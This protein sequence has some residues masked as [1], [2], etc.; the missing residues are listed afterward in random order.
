[1][2]PARVVATTF[3]RKA[4]Q[5]IRTRVTRELERL[6]L[7]PATSVYSASLGLGDTLSDDEVRVH[8][9]RAMSRLPAARFG[10]LHSFAMGIVRAHAMELGLGPGFELATELDSRALAE[11][12]IARAL[13]SRL[14]Q[15]E[16]VVR[17][18]AEA[19]GGVERLVAELRN[20]LVQLEEDGRSARDLAMPGGDVD[21]IERLVAALVEHAQSLTGAPKFD[22]AARDL[23]RAWQGGDEAAV[24]SATVA[25]CAIPALG[26]KSPEVEAFA[27]FRKALVGTTNE[28]KGRRLVRIY[29]MRHQFFEHARV[30]RDLLA[31]AEVD[32]ERESR[33]RAAIGFGEILRAARELLRD[34]PDVAADVGASI[35]A[36]LVDEFQDTSR[37]QRD[38]L[39]LLWAKNEVR[40]AG[41]VPS[42][43]SVRHRGLLVVGDR[44][45]SIYGFRGADVGV[46]A[47]LAVGL[48]GEPARQALGIAPGVTWEPREPLADFCALRYNR[49]SVAEVL[50]FVNAFSARRFCPADPPPALYEI[51]YVPSTEDLLVPPERAKHEAV[52][53]PP[54]ARTT[55]LRVKASGPTSTRMEEALVIAKRISTL[56]DSGAFR[57]KESEPPKPIAYRDLAVLASTNG[58]LDALAFALAQSNIPYV[59]AG[60]GF[61]RTREVRDLAAMLAWIVEPSDGQAALEVLRGPWAGLHDETLLALVRLSGGLMGVDDWL[62]L[63][64]PTPDASEDYRMLASIGALVTELARCA[65]RLGPGAVL[66]EVV[67]AVSFE[68]VL[69]ALPR[70]AQR[71]ANVRK[72]LIL[73][74]M[75]T[76][77][78]EFLAWLSEA[79]ERELGESEAATFSRDDDA[80]RLLTIHASKG[81]DFPVVFIPEIGTTRSR[82]DKGAVRVRTGTGDEPNVLSVRAAD[83]HGLVLE[84]PSFAEAHASAKRRD[85]AERQR[86]A[87]VAVTR[88]ADALYLVGGRAQE[89]VDVGASTLAV[90]EGLADPRASRDACFAIEEVDV[91]CS[92]TQRVE[93][94]EVKGTDVVGASPPP[95]VSRSRAWRSLP[96]APTALADFRSCPRRFELLHVVGLPERPRSRGVTAPSDRPVEVPGVALDAR[97][98]GT[99]AHAVLERVSLAAFGAQNAQEYVRE[100]ILAEGVIDGHPHYASVVA[101]VVPFLRGTFASAAAAAGASWRREV[102]FVL[103]IDAADGRSVVLRGT[104][105]LVVVWPDGSVDVVDYKSA[106]SG[107]SSAHAFQLDTYGLAARSLFP[108]AKRLRVGLLFLGGSADEAD[109]PVWRAL[110]DEAYL[111]AEIL[112]A[113]ESLINARY[114]GAF[115]RV[116]TGLCE[117]MH[118][119]FLGRC[120]GSPG[121]EPLGNTTDS[122]PPCATTT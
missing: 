80:V 81:L 56:V 3:S 10:T 36:L 72:L 27:L 58:M 100:A 22:A 50:T 68:D 101:R 94:P 108:S 110:A 76:D 84:P 73:A 121:V 77:S 38:V 21:A 33:A 86:V 16:G 104:I 85:R 23:V 67:R 30:V 59:V 42:I 6:A 37:V 41:H 17:S 57:L 61:Y 15:S 88:A 78:R 93:P 2:D 49:R 5:E 113:G 35:D 8:A 83:E 44:K 103:P 117:E 43:A 48:A 116:A 28:D 102:A 54:A 29:R 98:Q 24:E 89:D 97:A 18:L 60:K 114:V 92:V 11:D 53:G 118:C 74:D 66:R 55:W 112:S 31:A 12:A 99:L 46:F 111:R 107:H 75:H 19:A 105:D 120:H 32:I 20:L 40:Q 122:N 69:A 14:A 87:Y 47:E 13:E 45:Q 95:V 52:A 62:S 82:S 64:S 26:K 7:A 91:P 9:R 1:M 90:L 34:R 25:L 96:V 119:A 109:T 51:A 106:R 65:P 70:G 71:V 115:P 63:V 79:S 39:Q 4:A